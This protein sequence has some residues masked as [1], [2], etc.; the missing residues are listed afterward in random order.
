MD[1]NIKIL[2]T[3][4]KKSIFHKLLIKFQTRKLK[5]NSNLETY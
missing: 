4:D 5:F 2:Y 3:K 1:K